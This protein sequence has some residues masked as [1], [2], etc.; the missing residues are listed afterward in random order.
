M[1]HFELS[2]N[3]KEDFIYE[4]I[5]DNH[6]D[7]L[8]LTE[9]WCNSNSMVRLGYI[10]PA[11]Y[12]VIHTDIPTRGGGVA[13][14]FGDTYKAK[15]VK[16][17]KYTTFEHQA[18]SLHHGTNTHHM[19]TVYV[20]SGTFSPDFDDQFNW[21]TG[22]LL[23]LPGKHVIFS[24]FNFRIN[25]PTDVNAA[26]F[27]VLTEQFNLIQHVNLST[28][29]AGNTFDLVLTCDDVSSTSIHTDHSVNSDHCAVLF[30][31]S[32]VSP[33]TVRKSITYR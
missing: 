23:F 12:S 15:H 9:I 21:F 14:V 32:Y 22:I 20:P 18:V 27:N 10:T 17:G 8:A 2:F 30:N 4:P 16:T 29:I 5:V 11:G 25:E 33:G 7:L 26:K 31:W 24:D 13:L 1:C 3:N 6:L 28:H 19:T